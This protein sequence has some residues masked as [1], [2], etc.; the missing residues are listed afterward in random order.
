MHDSGPFIIRALL[1][2][3]VVTEADVERARQHAVEKNCGVVDALALMGVVSS[4]RLAIERARICEHPFVDLANYEVDFAN[5]ALLPRSLAE[6]HAAFPL[7]TAEGSVTVGMTDPLNLRAIDQLRQ[8]MKVDIDP[9]LCDGTQLEALIAR[10]YGLSGAKRESDASREVELTTGEEPIVVAVNQI[11][12]GAM[13]AGASDIHINPEEHRLLLRYRVDG[14]LQSVQAP[15]RSAHEGLVQRLKV[16]AQ[17]DLAQTRRPQDGKFRFTHRDQTVDFRLSVAPTI[18]GEN[19]VL[20]LL[21]GTATIGTI[22]E[23]MMPESVRAPYAHAIA[24][25]HGLIL[26]TGPTG[27]GKTT[28]LYVALQQINSPERNIVTI[29]DPVEI[30]LPV[31]RQIQVNAEIGLTFATALRSIL[32][33]D[34]D[35]ILVGEI[36]DQET[37]KIAVQAALTGHLVFSTLHTNDA[38]GAVTRLRDFDVPGFAVSNSLLCAIAQRLVRRVCGEC[39]AQESPDNP[40]VHALSMQPD[41]PS[42]RRGTGCSKCRNTGYRGR[43]GVYELLRGTPRVQRLIEAGGTLSDVRRAAA[44]E[45]MAPMWRDGADK[46]RR[47]LTT[48]DEIVRLLAHGRGE[49]QG[50]T[51][52]RMSA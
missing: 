5:A 49:E 3:G 15:A 14:V 2:E 23:L 46:A 26:V 1:A 29:E 12:V 16:M 27:S 42:L 10:A 36:R 39:A 31:V 20:R 33:Q 24:R 8:H 25:P 4:R 18:H 48:A 41:L 9:V 21:R 43:L 32:R 34:P 17:L 22:D 19:V 47:G 45:G 44:E 51:P 35:V 30:R 37:A 6:R 13:E 40:A 38:C 28:T 7:F 52:L 50:E 11:L